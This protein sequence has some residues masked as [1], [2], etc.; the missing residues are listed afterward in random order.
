MNIAAYTWKILR[1]FYRLFVE[2]VN[3]T[4][5]ATSPWKLLEIAFVEEV[6]DYCRLSV[7]DS[8]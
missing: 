8:E 1:Y 2:A 4:I 6:Y 7:E 3:S 5:F